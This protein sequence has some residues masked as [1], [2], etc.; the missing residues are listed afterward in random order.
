[1]HPLLKKCLPVNFP[2][3]SLVLFLH[4]TLSPWITLHPAIHALPETLSSPQFTLPPESSFSVEHHE[5][6]PTQEKRLQKDNPTTKPL[7]SVNPSPLHHSSRK[8][9]R[10][11]RKPQNPILPAEDTVWPKYHALKKLPYN[12]G[13]KLWH[14]GYHAWTPQKTAEGL[15][16]KKAKHGEPTS[17]N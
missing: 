7:H 2:S 6:S 10:R 3:S 5:N 4:E 11:S 9:A 17:G 12:N 15:G 16:K 14:Q 8:N 1:M 13:G